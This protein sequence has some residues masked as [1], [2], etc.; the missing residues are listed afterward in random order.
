MGV[1]HFFA[2]RNSRESPGQRVAAGGQV[3]RIGWGSIP[4]CAGR[5]AHGVVDVADVRAGQTVFRYA[6]CSGRGVRFP[7]KSGAGGNRTP[8]S[9]GSRKSWS[10]RFR[11]VESGRWELPRELPHSTCTEASA[12]CGVLSR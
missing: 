9:L 10:Q 7:S 6:E 12:M 1:T 8:A 2:A 5:F 3:P 11:A 4:D